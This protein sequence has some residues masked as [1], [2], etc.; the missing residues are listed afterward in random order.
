MLKRILLLIVLV[1][2]SGCDHWIEKLE[3]QETG[4]ARHCFELLQ[5]RD[6]AALENIAGPGLRSDDFASQLSEMAKMIPGEAPISSDATSVNVSTTNGYTKSSVSM[7]YQFPS[8]WLEFSIASEGSGGSRALTWISLRPTAAQA[9]VAFLPLLG[10]I[11]AVV[12]VLAL[13]GTVIYRRR[14]GRRDALRTTPEERA[15]RERWS[16]TIENAGAQEPWLYR[17]IGIRHVALNSALST[18]ACRQRLSASIAR[19][20]LMFRLTEPQRD[21]FQGRVG[22]S[23]F[24]IA[25]KRSIV[26]SSKYQAFL[27]GRLAPDAPGTRIHCWIGPQRLVLGLAI[28]FLLFAWLMFPTAGIGQ[29]G[30]RLF[31]VIF[32]LPPVL[33]TA[34]MAA[35]FAISRKRM[36]ADGPYLLDFLAQTLEA[37]EARAA[38][39]SSVERIIS[40]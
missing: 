3:P 28:V 38:R 21:E 35:G 17:L 10:L 33:V 19:E 2:A 30:L 1:V 31:D 16:S 14:I 6:F 22:R 15:R 11:P 29:G 5:H 24:R 25:R 9:S 39:S 18:E 4:F 26:F 12:I 34:F 13:I 7:V 23:V 36:L 37:T 32:L 20:S 8:G 40:R 27:Y